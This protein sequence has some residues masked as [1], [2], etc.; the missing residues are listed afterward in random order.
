MSFLNNE[1]GMTK[2][3]EEK[4]AVVFIP[5]MIADIQIGSLRSVIQAKANL[6]KQKLTEDKKKEEKQ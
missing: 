2:E 4:S 1:I 3:E 5:F 6:L